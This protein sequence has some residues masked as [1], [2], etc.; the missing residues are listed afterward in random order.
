MPD[1]RQ[2]SELSRQELYG[3]IWSSPATKV[4]ADFGVSDVA[5]HKRCIKLNIPRPSRGYWAKLAAGR[6]P[7]KKPLPPTADEVFVQLAQRHVGK[8]LALPENG[9]SLHPVASELLQALTKA[10]P[11]FQKHIG[12][13][14]PSLPEVNISK[15]LAQ[16]VAQ[17]FHVVLNALEPLGIL[18][19]KSQ[20]SYNPGYFKR[21]RERVFFYID[22]TLVDRFGT[23][24]RV[25]SWE[26]RD[27]GTPSGR[28]SFMFK[29]QLYG[30]G[31]DKQWTETAKVSLERLLSQIVSGIRLHFLEAHRRRIQEA[32]E[33]KKQQAE[34]EQRWR[35]WQAKEVIRLQKEKEQMHIKA[36]ELLANARSLDVIK[37]AELWR[38]SRAVTDFTDECERRWKSSSG[39]L[40]PEQS[41][42]L[43]WAR[44]IARA[45]S[46]FSVGYPDPSKHGAFDPSTIPVGGPYPSAQ[47]FPQLPTTPNTRTT[48]TSLTEL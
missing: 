2:I 18:F 17:A 11:E 47:N 15:D 45:Q 14:T 1:I 13:R 35:E 32:F 24:R 31:D 41:A 4:A 37:A 28:L 7:R 9:V 16:R 6:R 12:L 43:A 40:N 5:V 10:K 30:A 22:E 42:W 21:G 29:N 38:L 36:I 20:G 44:E 33:R 8:T 3:L 48:T 25:H 27:R 39:E 46:P 19:R 23:E 26:W 34:Y